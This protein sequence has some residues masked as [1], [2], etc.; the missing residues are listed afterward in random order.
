MS[1]AGRFIAPPGSSRPGGRKG[2]IALGKCLFS[3]SPR[4]GCDKRKMPATK[5]RQYGAIGAVL[6]VGLLTG[7]VVRGVASQ[8]HYALTIANYED[9]RLSCTQ[10]PPAA[11]ACQLAQEVA[12]RKTRTT[13]VRLVLWHQKDAP[14][15]SIVVPVNVL[16]PAGIGVRVDSNPAKTYPYTTCDQ[17]GC[18][19][20]IFADK[21]LYDSLVRASQIHV[22]VTSLAGKSVEIALSSK[23][24]R[25]GADNLKDTEAD[26][27]SWF[28]RA[29]L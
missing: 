14:T 11:A 1:I 7:W 3:A 29:F 12:D 17:G 18:L 4:S 5:M 2:W 25:D 13:I 28:R 19:A 9:W 22:V 26:S 27:R 6:A 20:S 10:Q 24:L 16:L 8:P 23:G 15:V 21:T